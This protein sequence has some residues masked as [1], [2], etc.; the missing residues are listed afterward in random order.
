MIHLIGFLLTLLLY[1]FVTFIG[2]FLAVVVAVFI[3]VA[4]VRLAWYGP[5]SS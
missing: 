2:P 1:A 4:V 5:R 3:L